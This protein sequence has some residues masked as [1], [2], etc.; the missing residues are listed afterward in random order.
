MGFSLRA[1][2]WVL[3]CVA[4][5][6]APA[7][8]AETPLLFRIGSGGLGGVYFPIAN[9]LASAISG[10]SDCP[11]RAACGVPGLLAVAQVSNGSVSNVRDLRDG[12]LEAGLVQA[13]VAY[14]AYHGS[15]AFQGEAPYAGLRAVA[16]LYS[17]YV[18]VVARTDSPIRSLA[19]L[20]GRRVSLDEPGSGT[21]ASA[22]LILK[23]FGLREADLQA[24]YLKTEPAA[25][26]L[27]EGR[28]DAFFLV[29][30]HPVIAIT[31]LA[32]A[33]PIRLIP[34]DG[35]PVMVLRT[36]RPYFLTGTIPADVYRGVAKT[37]TLEVGAQLL[38]DARLDEELVY[39]VTRA[40]W[41]E[42]T[43][44]ALSAAHARGAEIRPQRALDGLAI[45]LH[46]GAARYYRETG[47][48]S[49]S[50]T[51]P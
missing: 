28:L 14:G 27:R 5:A 11:E 39:R 49:T 51:R 17:E 26:A 13:D 38:V 4:A 19:D 25:K 43:Q 34:I 29:A 45:P 35:P 42:R 46:P 24:V 40:L 1:V 16:H 31:E 12:S 2:L 15:D 44:A 10:F 7:R 22:R 50:A 23:A 20:R 41:S 48:L 33:R 32:V 30:G 21:L 47:Q 36:Q 9:A 18:H 37:R 6:L 8:A 3:L